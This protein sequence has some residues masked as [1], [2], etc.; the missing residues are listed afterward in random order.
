M[1]EAWVRDAQ[2]WLERAT[3]PGFGRL[4][5]ARAAIL[6]PGTHPVDDPALPFSAGN[7][8]DD[9]MSEEQVAMLSALLLDGGTGT[10]P[11]TRVTAALYAGFLNRD[12][13]PGAR[14]GSEW[15]PAWLD[16]YQSRFAVVRGT[17]TQLHP[18]AVLERWGEW[19]ELSDLWAED[20]SWGLTSPPD[21]A[22]SQLGGSAALI[23]RALGTEG[24]KAARWPVGRSGTV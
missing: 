9:R 1:D 12:E 5:P 22:F 14:D 24:L 13:L 7:P 16:V 10:G 18:E 2:G 17:L 20:G 23:A 3:T 8:N 19:I 6:H 15:E 21:L 11:Q 4:F